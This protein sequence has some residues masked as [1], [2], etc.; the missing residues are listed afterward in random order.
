MITTR[1]IVNLSALKKWGKEVQS[2][3][4]L[5]VVYKKWAVR[6][7]AFL[8]KR[9]DA[10]SKGDGTWKPLADSTIAGRRKGSSTILRDTGVLFAALTPTWVAPPG[11]VNELIDGGVRVG[12]GGSESHPGGLVTIADIAGFHQDGGGNLPKREIMVDPPQAVID[13]C[14]EDLH[15]ELEKSTTST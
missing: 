3:E 15:K 13:A 6:Y 9:F 10:A 14:I 2:S 1:I 5:T 8:Q 11:S 12:F 4:R 7:R